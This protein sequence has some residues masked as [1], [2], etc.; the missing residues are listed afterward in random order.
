LTETRSVT[1]RCPEGHFEIDVTV[2]AA[3]IDPEVSGPLRGDRSRP[4]APVASPEEFVDLA[5]GD[6]CLVCD[7]TIESAVR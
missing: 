4:R 6:E 1:L 3:V 2:T 5:P 7:Q